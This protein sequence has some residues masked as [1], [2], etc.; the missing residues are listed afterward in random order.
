MAK[1]KLKTY[2]IG[3]LPENERDFFYKI[4]SEWKEAQSSEIVAI[5]KALEELEKY[6]ES[7]NEM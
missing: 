4:L 2:D 5:K 7:K 6:R 3:G 1:K